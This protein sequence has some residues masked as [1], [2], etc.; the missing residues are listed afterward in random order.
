MM[1]GVMACAAASG[2][3]KR[4]EAKRETS[5]V[6]MVMWE[7]NRWWRCWI[8]LFYKLFVVCVMVCVILWL[9]RL[10]LRRARRR[11]RADLIVTV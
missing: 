10:M 2:D 1:V 9:V 11:F 4:R 8:G 7:L 5:M 3:A 6:F